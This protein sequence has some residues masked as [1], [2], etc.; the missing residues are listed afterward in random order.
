M[1][2]ESFRE[3][4]LAGVAAAVRLAADDAARYA[5]G[6]PGSPSDL[7][8]EDLRPNVSRIGSNRPYAKAQE[9]GAFIVPRR[10]RALHFSDGRWRPRARIKPKRY[11]ARTGRRWGEFLLGRLR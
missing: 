5:G 8:A 10:G 7:H 3:N 4:V 2:I 6:L 9:R 1:R 11:L